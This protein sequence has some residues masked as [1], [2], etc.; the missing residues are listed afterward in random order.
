MKKLICSNLLVALTINL[1]AVP[2]AHG[3][4]KYRKHKYNKSRNYRRK[5]RNFS[6]KNRVNKKEKRRK[7]KQQKYTEALSFFDK[8]KRRLL[9]FIRRRS[10]KANKLNTKKRNKKKHRKKSDA[11]FGTTRYSSGA[12]ISF[13]TILLL[14]FTLVASGNSEWTCVDG[15]YQTTYRGNSYGSGDELE[16]K[17]IHGTF[18]GQL[19]RCDATDI[20]QPWECEEGLYNFKICIDDHLSL[21]KETDCTCKGNFFSKHTL[22]C[23]NINFYHS[24][25][26]CSDLNKRKRSFGS[27]SLEDE[28][29]CDA[30]VTTENNKTTITTKC[31]LSQEN[32]NINTALA[33]S[34]LISGLGLGACLTGLI[35]C[36]M[37]EPCKRKK[38]TENSNSIT[39]EEKENKKEQDETTESEIDTETESETEQ[40]ET[41]E[42]NTDTDTDTEE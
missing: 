31:P 38:H 39:F 3:G 27:S 19:L 42:T 2:F 26:I 7:N 20:N 21:E 18:G 32:S 23:G 30:T 4:K 13:G 41:T 25:N 8:E 10:I 6:Y 14:L 34:S 24:S 11:N 16:C 36:I 9:R 33:I 28:P 35:A 12:K 37:C 40:D 15:I 1:L 29:C 5:E 17:C 22:D